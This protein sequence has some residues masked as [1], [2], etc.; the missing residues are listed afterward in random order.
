[1][2]FVFSQCLHFTLTAFHNRYLDK[3]LPDYSLLPVIPLSSLPLSLSLAN[4]YTRNWGQL[5]G[6]SRVCECVNVV[7]PQCFHICGVGEGGVL[8]RVC[9]CA[10]MFVC[11]LFT[12]CFDCNADILVHFGVDSRLSFSVILHCA[13]LHCFQFISLCCFSDV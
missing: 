4:N 9:V 13:T 7:L 3:T 8:V 6:L 2:L 5:I 1:M 12:Y 10:R 11:V